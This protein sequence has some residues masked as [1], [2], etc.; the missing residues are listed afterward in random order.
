MVKLAPLKKLC[1]L[2]DGASEGVIRC[3]GYRWHIC[4]D[5]GV[6]MFQRVG[7]DYICFQKYKSPDKNGRL[8]TEI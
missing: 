1:E 7:V 4:R 8:W 6:K 5:C 3:G 2:C